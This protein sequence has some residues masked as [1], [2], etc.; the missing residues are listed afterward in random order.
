[1]RIIRILISLR[2]DRFREHFSVV[3]MKRASAEEVPESPAAAKFRS[4]SRDQS[5]C[6]R[7]RDREG[8]E[9]RVRP[10]NLPIHRKAVLARRNRRGTACDRFFSSIKNGKSAK[11]TD[12][13]EVRRR[14]TPLSEA[15][16]LADGRPSRTD[17]RFLLTLNGNNDYGE[18]ATL[19][20]TSVTEARS[21]AAHG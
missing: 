13:G 9:K 8:F 21:A 3:R 10:E 18:D 19:G 5:D 16:P 2:P 20:K 15:W 17:I 4:M 1:M 6:R 12:R 7:P 11:G 14:T